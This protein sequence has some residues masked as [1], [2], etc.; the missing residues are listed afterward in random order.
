VVNA[1]GGDDAPQLPPRIDIELDCLLFVLATSMAMMDDYQ[2]VVG[3][4]DWPRL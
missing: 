2:S 4:R 3:W 1:V